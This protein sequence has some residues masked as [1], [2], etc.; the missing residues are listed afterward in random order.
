MSY[1]TLI[2]TLGNS[3][4]GY[5]SATQTSNRNHGRSFDI[6][7]S[8]RKVHLFQSL[9]GVLRLHL[10]R[11]RPSTVLCAGTSL[12]LLLTPMQ[13]RRIDLPVRSRY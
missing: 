8:Q 6:E 3:V 10:R 11:P 4:Q 12:C 2:T 7:H 1:T 5:L 9:W 13:A